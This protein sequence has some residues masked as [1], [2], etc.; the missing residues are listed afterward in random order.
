MFAEKRCQLTCF[1]YLWFPRLHVPP[2]RTRDH[3]NRAGTVIYYCTDVLVIEES[4][5]LG[6]YIYFLSPALP[7]LWPV[8]VSD[9]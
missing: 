4:E 6:P 2:F 7:G 9:V 5:T 1:V 3:A 8:V